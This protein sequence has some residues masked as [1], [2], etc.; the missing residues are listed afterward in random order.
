MSGSDHHRPESVCFLKCSAGN[1][2]DHCFKKQDEMRVAHS[3]S[4]STFECLT[5]D[6]R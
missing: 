1:V 5:D 2:E 6:Y 4:I 3:S